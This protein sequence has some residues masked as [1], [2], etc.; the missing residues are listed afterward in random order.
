[1]RTSKLGVLYDKEQNIRPD[2]NVVVQEYL[3]EFEAFITFKEKL[4]I[5]ST[6]INGQYNDHEIGYIIDKFLALGCT[7]E[8]Q[9]VK[10]PNG[11]RRFVLTELS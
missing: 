8:Y 11:K 9:V 7:V 2:L 5:Y 1:M 6:P 10:S 4:P 3:E